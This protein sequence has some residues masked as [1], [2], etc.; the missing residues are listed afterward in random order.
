MGA[1]VVSGRPCRSSNAKL[2][3]NYAAAD[4]CGRVAD[5]RFV[6]FLLRELAGIGLINELA[7]KYLHLTP[8]APPL[9]WG[10]VI[11]GSPTCD[12]PPIIVKRSQKPLA[13]SEMGDV[14]GSARAGRPPRT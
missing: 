7:D 4:F 11:A 2:A 14:S 12:I 6:S 13:V 9:L 10:G 8:P 5:R 1:D 3:T